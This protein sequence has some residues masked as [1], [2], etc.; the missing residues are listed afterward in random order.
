LTPTEVISC[1]AVTKAY[2]TIRALQ[3]ISLSI[4]EGESVAVVGANGAGKSTLFNIMVGLLQ[5][6]DGTCSI[7]GTASGQ[8]APQ[9]RA[10][11]GFI[12]D[13]AG[14]I[15]WATS[16]DL[17]QL[18]AKIYPKWDQKRYEQ[19]IASWKIDS[20]RRLKNLSKGQ[21]RLAEIALVTAIQPALLILDEP[22]DG[23]DAVMRIK[24]QK[25]LRDLQEKMNT[26]ILYATHIV[27]E[28]SSVADRMVVLQNGNLIYDQPLT[29]GG[30]SPDVLFRKLYAV[31]IEG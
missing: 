8:L 24:I 3:N 5:P 20:Y 28:L 4:N 6:D 10:K 13:H 9:H 11:I 16:H 17:A 31:E 27:T 19:V 12:A 22:F 2:G 23:L 25:L 7:A 15:P 29:C 30:E 18:Y 26:T 14:P 1:R 21:K